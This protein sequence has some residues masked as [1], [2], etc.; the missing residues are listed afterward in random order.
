MLEIFVL[1]LA[2]Q[3]SFKKGPFYSSCTYIPY[4]SGL[5][6]MTWCGAVTRMTMLCLAAGHNATMA[7]R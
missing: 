7:I 4:M 1:V 5:R 3:W 6:W 2:K